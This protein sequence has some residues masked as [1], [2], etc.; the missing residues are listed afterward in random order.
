MKKNIAVIG[1]TGSIGSTFLKV[2]DKYGK[3]DFRITLLS[4][5]KNWKKLLNQAIKYNVKNVIIFHKSTFKNIFKQKIFKKKKINLFNDFE[6]FINSYKKKFYYS[7]ISITGIYGLQPTLNI[8]KHTNKLAIANKESIICAWSIICKNL[9]KFETNFIPIDSEHFSLNEL[10]SQKKITNIKKIFLTASGGPFLDFDK[11]KFNNIQIKDAIR[12]PTWKMGKKISIDSATMINKVYEVIEAKKIFKLK[13]SMIDILIQPTSMVH[14]IV[15]FINGTTH[16]LIHK[17][18]MKVPIF[19]SLIKN[20]KFIHSEKFENQ[21]N[22]VN[23][24]KLQ[25]VPINKFPIKK[26]LNLIPDNESLFETIL[27]AA[28]DTLVELFLMKKIKFNEIHLNLFKILKMRKFQAYRM[29]R[30][31]NVTQIINLYREVRL[32]TKKL[33]VV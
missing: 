29:I 12:H 21:L 4:A 30:P 18:T 11:S 27:L 9:K 3:D 14:S 23:D 31:K 24:L 6:T 15:E 19:N 17:P 8:I 5:N 2:F 32:K 7:I 25:N 10:I 13:Y 33:S 26:I 16:F 20:K 28:N 22:L 1:S